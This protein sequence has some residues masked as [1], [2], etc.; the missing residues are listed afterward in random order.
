MADLEIAMEGR[1]LLEEIAAE[2]T[3]DDRKRERYNFLMKAVGLGEH[4][5]TLE[6]VVRSLKHVIGLERQAFGI[7][8]SAPGD[9]EDTYEAR[10]KRLYDQNKHLAEPLLAE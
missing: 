1:L 4:A 7:D 6:S 9:P 8:D 10:L 5:G 3:A 2:V